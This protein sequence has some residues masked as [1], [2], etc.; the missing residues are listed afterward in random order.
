MVELWDSLK[1]EYWVVWMEY[2][3]VGKM[4][5][6]MGYLLVGWTENC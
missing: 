2:M 3:L 1:V 4:D 6:T 5:V